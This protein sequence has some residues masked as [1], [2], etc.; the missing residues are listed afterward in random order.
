MFKFFKRS[1]TQLHSDLSFLSVDMH[2]HLLPGIDD[3]LHEVE[4]TIEFVKELQQL[5]YRKLIC[6][7]HILADLYPNTPGTILP[8]LAMVKKALV[9]ANIDIKIE[10]AAEYMIDHEFTE[11]IARSKKED[12]LTIKGEYLLVEVPFSAPLPNFD[13]V[14]F[15]IRM[16][17]IQPI[18]AHPERYNYL[19][20]QFNQYERF[21]EL[22][23]KLQVNL[24]SL[25]GAYG[26][27]VKKTAEKLIKNN[28][29]D[30]F[31]TDM[32]H[33]KHLSM[34]KKLALKKEFHDLLKNA[35][36]LNKTLL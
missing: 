9:E 33:E 1:I 31:G 11:L 24:L 10:A 34:L 7:P 12:L 18:L 15:D 21:R 13:K 19:H 20:N 28:M 30:F 8:Q 22:G 2:S 29:V 27:Q 4:Q 5:G 17:G 25:S 35:E 14:I 32:H 16:L 3:G 36:V 6:T 26:P 23:C